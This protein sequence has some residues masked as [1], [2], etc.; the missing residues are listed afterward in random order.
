MDEESTSG[1]ALLSKGVAL[2]GLGRFEEAIIVLHDVIARFELSN[3]PGAREV[4][5]RAL[6]NQ[7]VAYNRLG[8]SDQAAA[9]YDE[10]VTRFGASPACV[11]AS[12]RRSIARPAR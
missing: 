10:T 9:V 4:V 5:A 3:D 12:R 6:F 2:G 11:S 8:R 7:G 1:P